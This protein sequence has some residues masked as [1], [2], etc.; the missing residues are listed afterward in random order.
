[1]GK[2]VV[3]RRQPHSSGH[4]TEARRLD[5]SKSFL[6]KP[7]RSGPVCSED[8]PKGCSMQ[9]FLDSYVQDCEQEY[10]NIGSRSIKRQRHGSIGKDSPQRTRRTQSL[11]FSS[12]SSVCSVLLMSKF[13]SAREDFFTTARQS[14]K[15][16]TGVRSQNE[17]QILPP[18][19]RQDDTILKWWL[20]SRT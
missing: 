12:V 14:R 9:R 19:G 7:R 2:S 20:S 4:K 16:E 3:Y 17:Q 10:F 6:E 15:Q 5:M 13:F 8:T 11:F 1:M 18:V